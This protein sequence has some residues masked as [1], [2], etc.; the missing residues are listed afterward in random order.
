M[1]KKILSIYELSGSKIMNIHIIP[2]RQ[3][4][5]NSVYTNILIFSVFIA[6]YI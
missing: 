2:Q 3:Q 6:Q 1:I 4:F 5:I